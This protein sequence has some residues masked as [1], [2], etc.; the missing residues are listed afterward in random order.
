MTTIN[1]PIMIASHQEYYDTSHFISVPNP[2]WAE[3][4]S[5]GHTHR[6]MAVGDMTFH[7][8]KRTRKEQ[9]EAKRMR[10]LGLPPPIPRFVCKQ[11][12]DVVTPGYTSE[13]VEEKIPGPR[14]ATWQQRG[15]TGGLVIDG[16]RYRTSEAFVHDGVTWLIIS[17]TTEFPNDTDT[18][19]T[20]ETMMDANG[21]VLALP[22][23]I[24]VRL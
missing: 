1:P 15:V 16:V 17:I 13:L 5:H 20:A 9:R 22:S 6:W 7:A 21:G 23:G 2:R 4:D 12:G 24:W 18:L 10:D 11:C 3:I 14:Y 8:A 19:V